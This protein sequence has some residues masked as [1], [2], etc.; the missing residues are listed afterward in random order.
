VQVPFVSL[1]R[2]FRDLHDELL[3][4]FERVGAS[5]MY[6]LG[7]E[8]ERFEAEV[9][10]YC[11]ARY[12]LGV[13]NGSDALFLILK[14]LGVGPGHEVITCPNSFIA[15]AWVIVAAGARP[16]FVD[17]AEDSNIDVRRI[18]AAVTPRTRALIAVHLTGR[19]VEMDAVNAI[20]GKHAFAVIED[21]AQ[22][23]GARYKGRRVGSLATAGGFS[24]H[25]LKNLG[26]YGDG[27]LVTTNDRAI[28]ER[29]LKLRN[30]GLRSRDECE[31]W[32]YNSRLDPLQAAFASVKLKRLDPWN[33]RCREI[34]ARY[35]D[36]LADV[37]WVPRDR[38][39]E[40][41]VYHNFIIRSEQRDRLIEHLARC[42]VG[43][44]IHY[45]IPIHLQEC[46]RHLGH[47]EGDYPE[48]E[49]QA[50]TILSLPIFPELTE[51]E[52]AHVIGSVRSFFHS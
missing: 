43:T 22:A 42:G 52:I 14:A 16:V 26:V 5:G 25:P 29:V 6:V 34:A 48:A 36:G 33:A 12:A 2:Q 19:P 47:R 49:R 38:A 27:G 24:L 44:R 39:H 32:G 20:A 13:A 8:L 45:P 1:E 11:G 7:E 31:T 9:A 3:A 15:S 23:I 18:D 40:E 17:A 28:Y 50:R 41:P 37:V 4:A 51:P 10:A 21:A 46:A 30:H 35:R